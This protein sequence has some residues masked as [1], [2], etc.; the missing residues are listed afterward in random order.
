MK[1]EKGTLVWRKVYHHNEDGVLEKTVS[2]LLS[3]K[4]GLRYFGNFRPVR[5]AVMIPLKERRL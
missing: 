1:S 4:K 5:K 2:E 3:V